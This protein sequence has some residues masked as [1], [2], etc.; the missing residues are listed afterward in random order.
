MKLFFLLLVCLVIGPTIAQNSSGYVPLS[1][2]EYDDIPVPFMS[3]NHLKNL[4]TKY[5]IS[6]DYFPAAGN[7]GD[8]GSCTTWATGYAVGSFYNAVKNKTGKPDS[9]DKIMSPAFIYHNIRTCH[10]GP[11]CGTSIAYAL[12]LFRD[13][14]LITMAELPFDM[15]CQSPAQEDLQKSSTLRIKDYNKIRDKLNFNE[16]K[17]YLSNDVPIIT[18]T[19]LGSGFTSFYQNSSKF[20][21]TQVEE[22]GH[23]MVIVGYDDDKRAFKLLNSWGENWGDKGYIWV[24]YDCF[25]IMMGAPG[26]EAYVISKDYELP[27]QAEPIENYH[28]SESYTAADFQI[29]GV[30]KELAIDNYSVSYGI[31]TT[32][33]QEIVSIQY[34]FDD[35]SFYERT[36]TSSTGPYYPVSYQGAYCLEE[37]TAVVLFSDGTIKRL[38]FNGCE[39][40]K[41]DNSEIVDHNN[42]DQVEIFPH[43]E[44]ASNPNQANYYKFTINLHGSELIGHQI[45][46]VVYDFNHSSFKNRYSTSTNPANGYAISYNGW[47]CLRN[48]IATIYFHDGST[49]QIEIDM[50]NEIGW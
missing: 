13:Q 21:C 22:G 20:T 17:R 43:V 44:V 2:D 45:E 3:S 26:G 39:V 8:I 38:K 49:S 42:H 19:S 36:I 10:C 12:N 11:T 16:Y 35:P 46:K 27:K 23:A 4:P 41:S 14:G 6:E 40:L 1:D 47:G 31:S 24:D 33:Q 15:T 50:C 25:K 29:F 48:L 28:E 37:I 7:Q 5:I 18:G 32:I 34:E 30:Y 9:P